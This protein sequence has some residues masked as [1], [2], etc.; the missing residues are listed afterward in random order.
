MFVLIYV[1]FA[2]FIADFL[3]QTRWMA[4]NKSK[5][6]FALTTHVG[7]YSLAMLLLVLPLILLN[8]P[9]L[10]VCVF[11]VANAILHFTTDY[12]TSKTSSFFWQKEDMY[13]FFA[14]VGF[15]Q[16]IHQVCLIM[17]TYV[18]L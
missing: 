1:L 13:K 10:S 7:A 18:F 4:E 5:S 15:D 12:V 9:M 14:T 16:Y 2:H 6:V 8:V 17:T 3:C 11:V